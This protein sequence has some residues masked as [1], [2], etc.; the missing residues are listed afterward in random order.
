MESRLGV[1][2]VSTYCDLFV[3]VALD[4]EQKLLVR[5]YQHIQVRNVDFSAGWMVSVTALF[6]CV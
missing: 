4:G 1:S 3:K 6:R 5:L 2:G